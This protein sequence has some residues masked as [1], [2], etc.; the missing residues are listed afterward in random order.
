VTSEEL[1]LVAPLVA[2]GAL[3][4]GP[5]EECL[6]L[7][8]DLSKQAKEGQRVS[9]LKVMVKKALLTET[10]ALVLAEKPLVARQ[11]FPDYRLLRKV[12][13]GG[14]A[15][16]YEATYTPVSARVALKILRTEFCLQ[17]PYRLRFKREAQMLLM[18]DHENIVEG[19]EY[20]THD[21]VDF[22]AMGFVDGIS[23]LSI[24][25][26]HAPIGEGLALHVT[27]Q[28]ASALEH[29]R[30]KGVVHRDIKPGNLVIDSD[31]TVRIIDFGLAKI[32][33][34]MWQD[35]GSETT[36]GTLEYMSPE[37]AR[38]ESNVDIRA[39]IYSLGVT[40]FQMITGELPFQGTAAE[41]MYGHV[42]KDL[43]FTPAQKAKVSPQV[44]FILR[45]TMAK[46]RAHR[47]ET[48]QALVDDL[49][50]VCGALIAGRGPVPDIVHSASVEDAP[51]SLTAPRPR[52]V[53]S[54]RAG[55]P[56]RGPHRPSSRP[57]PRRHR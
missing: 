3:P 5:A 48:P 12:D 52:P 40:L 55:H 30:Q 7:W 42:K 57:H 15:T 37:Q 35:V 2:S 18:L 16:V 36:V 14:M 38:G 44:Q 53:V 17:E 10:Q 8:Q 34:G 54:P 19:R 51:I 9:L 22:Y 41:I 4:R 50:A 33:S 11:P 13:E 32:M 24:L 25:D 23:I 6:R 26:K 1:E 28:V 31:G 39:D 27:S 47:Y 46:D 21:G 56:S 43:E 49:Q 45:K 29:M 20:K